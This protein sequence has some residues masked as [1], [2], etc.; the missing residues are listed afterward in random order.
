MDNEEYKNALLY[1]DT[2]HYTK[3]WE[4]GNTEVECKLA[5]GMLRL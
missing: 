3:A 2:G 4:L 1:T 5:T